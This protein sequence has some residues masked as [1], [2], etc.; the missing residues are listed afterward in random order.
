MRIINLIEDARN[1][2]EEEKKEEIKES[3]SKGRGSSTFMS[4]LD[5]LPKISSEKV[6]PGS[7]NLQFR[8][9]WEEREENKGKTDLRMVHSR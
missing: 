8:F 6:G 5:R 2:D 3:P 7:Y 1:I 4:K 9:S